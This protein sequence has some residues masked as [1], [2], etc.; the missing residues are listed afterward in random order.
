MW[1]KWWSR[2][3]FPSEIFGC[4]EYEGQSSEIL[5][6]RAPIALFHSKW[7]RVSH[8]KRKIT[9]IGIKARIEKMNDNSPSK[10]SKWYK[11]QIRN[12]S[13]IGKVQIMRNPGADESVHL[14]HLLLLLRGL[15]DWRKIFLHRWNKLREWFCEKNKLKDIELTSSLLPLLARLSITFFNHPP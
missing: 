1:N 14:P 5:N 11:V 4:G 8:Q 6:D 9:Y 10:K 12:S 15:G 2:L 7:W 13:R 3:K